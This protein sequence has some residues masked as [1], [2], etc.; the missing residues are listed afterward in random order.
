[1]STLTIKGKIT[2]SDSYFAQMYLDWNQ[3][4][5]TTEHALSI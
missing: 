2:I 1:M 5:R 4:L 3:N